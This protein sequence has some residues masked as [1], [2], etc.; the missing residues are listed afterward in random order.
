MY[1]IRSYY[2][3]LDAGRKLFDAGKFTQA[4]PYFQHAFEVEPNS[5]VGRESLLLVADSAFQEG[6]RTELVQAEAKYR[7]F[8]NRFLV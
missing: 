8:L 7:D 3:S 2:E 1:A 5:A 6:G 4:R